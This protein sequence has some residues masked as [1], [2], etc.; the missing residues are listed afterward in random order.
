[1][2]LELLDMLLISLLHVTDCSDMDFSQDISLSIF[3][4]KRTR[5]K[6]QKVLS[7]PISS[8]S[9]DSPQADVANSQQ[10]DNI[11]ELATSMLPVNAR[12]PICSKSIITMP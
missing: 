12:E 11:T 4:T 8:I 5:S 9:K 3:C 7:R 1:M 10:M 6:A 2:E